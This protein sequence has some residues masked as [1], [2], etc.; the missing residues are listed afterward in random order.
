[1]YLLRLLDR[2]LGS[3]FTVRYESLNTYMLNEFSKCVLSTVVGVR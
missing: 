3:V 1:M 2:D